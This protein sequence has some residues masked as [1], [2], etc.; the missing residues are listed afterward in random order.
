[1]KTYFTSVIFGLLFGLISLNANAAEDV[2]LYV[3]SGEQFRLIP[4]GPGGAVLSGIASFIWK[5]DNGLLSSG[6]DGAGILTQTLTLGG[7][8][9]IAETKT[10]TL[11]LTSTVGSCL[12]ELVTYVVH[13]LPAIITGTIADIGTI[14]SDVTSIVATLTASSELTLPAGISIKYVWKKG[15]ETLSSVT[16]EQAITDV[17]EYVATATYD[18]GDIDPLL[19]KLS[20]VTPGT[21][22]KTVSR[23]AAVVTP[24]LTLD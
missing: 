15:T 7:T 19:T 16:N 4:K 24:I 14:C 17:G 18:I 12:S 10:Y 5:L 22:T 20:S 1:M 13:V 6:I 9:K 8:G 11:Q 3:T 2:H 23:L 21:L